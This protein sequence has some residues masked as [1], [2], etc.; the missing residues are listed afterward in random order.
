MLP[1]KEVNRRREEGHREAINYQ[2]VKNKSGNHIALG[3]EGILELELS[4][5]VIT[6]FMSCDPVSS[7]KCPNKKS[8]QSWGKRVVEDLYNP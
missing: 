6:A 1:I 8:T 7:P 5:K 4:N 2:Y 3:G